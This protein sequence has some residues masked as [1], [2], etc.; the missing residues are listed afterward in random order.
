MKP[1][2]P[3]AAAEDRLLQAIGL[4]CLYVALIVGVNASGK[5][6]TEDHHP[7]QVVFFRHGVAFLLMLLLFA[8]RHGPRILVPRRPGLQIVRGLLAIASSIFY[9][10][11]LAALPLATAA[12]ISF[13]SPL[14]VTALSVPLLAEK[15][16]ARRWAAVAVGFAGAMI[17]IRPA[18]G[19]AEWAA[20]FIVGSAA[21]GA[22]YQICTRKLAGQDHAETTNIWSG[23]VGAAVMCVL[24]PFVWETPTDPHVWVL[25]VSIGLVGG[26]AHYLLTKAFERGPASLLSPFNYLQLIGA[27]VTGW[28]LYRDLPDG[29]TWVG[30]AVIVAA[31]LYIAHR[32][33][34]D[35]A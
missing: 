31:G 16:G 13:T 7:H 29:W 15:V 33:S 2:T 12:A 23:L 11:G 32:E 30:A 1:A 34:R 28:L 25:F 8:P 26:I 3:V 4:M 24:V 18:G 14:L 20:L 10:T 22:L 5:V 6:L 35:R 19:S 27:T 9:F 21:C 17:V